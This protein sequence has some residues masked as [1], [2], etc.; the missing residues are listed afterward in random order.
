MSRPGPAG[1]K[2]PESVLVVL[3]T[4]EGEVLMLRR[5]EPPDFWQSVTGSLEWD[6]TA[7]AAARR[8]LREETGLD[9]PVEDR[10]IVNRFSILPAW[11]P[12]YAPGATVNTEYVFTARLEA[13]CPVRLNPRE[14]R[15]YRWLPWR[16]AAELAS[17]WTN[18]DAILQLVGNQRVDNLD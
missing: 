13:P 5:R 8:E 1:Y 9:L 16:E 12:R 4:D 7:P 11:R 2:R 15:A 3:Y 17:S 6:E 10:Q 18:R 14:H